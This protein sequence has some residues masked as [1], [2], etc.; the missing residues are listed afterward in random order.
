MRFST[1][2]ALATASIGF[3]AAQDGPTEPDTDPDCSFWDTA[4]DESMDCA[5][6]ESVWGMS[7]K[8]FVAW[9]PS[10]KDDCSGIKVGYSYCMEAPPPQATTTTKSSTTAGPTITPKPSPTQEGLIDTCTAFYKAVKGDTCDKIVKAH[11]TFSLS[12]FQ[13]WNPAVGDDCSGLWAETYYCV[14][15]PG[16]PTSPPSPP[17][18]STTGTP[19]PSPTQPGLIESCV[20]FYKAVKGDTCDKIVTQYGTFTSAQFTTWNPAVGDDCSGL[21]ADTYYCVGIPGT[22]TTKPPTSTTA[23]A[24]GSPKPSPTQP[25]LIGTCTRFYKAVSGD[26]CDKIVSK[27]GTFT[28][29]QFKTWNPAVGDDCSGLWLDTYYCVGIPGTPT[30][31]PPTST[32]ASATGSPKP[33]PT[34]PGLIGTCTKFYKAVSGDTCDKIVSK[35][36]TFTFAQFK[37]WNPAV[38]DD[39]SGLWLNTYYCVGIPGTPTTIRTSTTSTTKGNGVPTP[40]P[41]Q[42]GMVNN[43]KTFYLVKSGETCDSIAKKHGITTAQLTKWNTGVGSNCSGMWANAYL[44]VGLI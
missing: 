33:S 26:T 17:A 18:T 41:T 7:H 14:G 5:Y 39:C 40:T 20:R 11:G 34:Q 38:G 23:S 3:S 37:T 22:P 35:Y 43:C 21:W 1:L 2:L 32:T 4:Y 13:T 6:F 30:T 24:T 44:C 12:E 15:I 25:G 9:N 19:K 8:D 42:P 28:F 31:K 29:A 10:V 16:T 36:G 27:Y